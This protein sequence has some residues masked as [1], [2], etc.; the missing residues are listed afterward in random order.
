MR[1]PKLEGPIDRTTLVILRCGDPV[2]SVEERRGP[3]SS[4]IAS[5]LARGFA[6]PMVE[7]DVRTEEPNGHLL[8]AAGLVLTGSSSSVTERAAWMLKTEALLVR[9]VEHDV[10]VLGICFGHQLLAQALGGEVQ[11]NPRG[12]EIG[13]VT[14]RSLVDD[15]LFSG[16]GS[17][18]DVNATHVDSVVKRPHGA[19]V[20]A[21]TELEPTAAFAV[22]SA[23]G[24]Q[25]HPEVDGD[26]M[27]GYLEARR[28]ILETEGFDVDAMLARAGDTP[29]GEKMLETFARELTR[30]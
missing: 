27:R 7:V 18:F 17:V 10:P 11:K 24:V 1:V 30:R 5:S 14:V 28:A 16:L 3:F 13:R 4:W 26:V 20:L 21:E 22:G 2:A 23:R 9:A 25:F 15:A 8:H 19:T 29:A 12:R 6:G